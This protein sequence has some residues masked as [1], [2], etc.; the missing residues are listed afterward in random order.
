MVFCWEEK[1][2]GEGKGSEKVMLEVLLVVLLV[3]Q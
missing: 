2:E 1:R 3:L